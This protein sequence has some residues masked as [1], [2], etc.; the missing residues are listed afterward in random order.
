MAHICERRHTQHKTL[1]DG[2]VTELQDNTLDPQAYTNPH[3]HKNTK[4]IEVAN[5]LGKGK[6]DRKKE[7]KQGDAETEEHGS[8]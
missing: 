6:K 2:T 4:A 5:T 3:T 7:G 1:Y 8:P